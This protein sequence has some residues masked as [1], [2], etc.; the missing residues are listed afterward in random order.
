MEQKEYGDM[1]RSK[2][3]IYVAT[4]EPGNAKEKA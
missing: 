2:R 1:T 3:K 4:R